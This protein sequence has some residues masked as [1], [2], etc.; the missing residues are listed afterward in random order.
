MIIGAAHTEGIIKLLQA[1]KTSFAVITPAALN[2]DYG[3]LSTE[4]FNRK[5]KMQ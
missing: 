4:Q 2:P 5:N 1:K 3:S